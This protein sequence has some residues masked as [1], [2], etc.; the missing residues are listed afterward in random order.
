MKF[1]LVMVFLLGT[2]GILLTMRAIG[3]VKGK[4][5]V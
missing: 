2:L 5:G 1:L 3:R 4:A